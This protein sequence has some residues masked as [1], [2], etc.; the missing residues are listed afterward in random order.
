MPIWK[1]SYFAKNHS[2]V[3]SW[4]KSA[5][6]VLPWREKERVETKNL[7]LEVSAGLR[8]RAFREYFSGELRRDPYRVVVA[9][10]MLQQTQ[11]DRVLPKYQAWMEKWPHIED[12]ARAT[13]AEV[14][15]EW[16]GLGYN[17]RARFLWLLAK[18][19]GETRAGRWPRTEQELLKLPGIGR[20][21]ARAILSF[22]FGQQVA[23]V[24]T[25][26]KRVLGR[27][28]GLVEEIN[29]LA[30]SQERQQ[31]KS[32]AFSSLQPWLNHEQIPHTD[33]NL[34]ELSKL[35]EVRQTF[36]EYGRLTE[37]EWFALADSLL[38]EESADPWNQA[39]MDFGALVC[40]AKNP[41]CDSCPVSGLCVTNQY[42]IS[43]GCDNYAGYLR[44]KK[45]T[46]DLLTGTA[47]H[48]R[49]KMTKSKDWKDGKRLKFEETDRYFRGRILD[50]LR[51]KDWI[52]KDLIE[53]MSKKY[54]LNDSLR[55]HKMLGASHQ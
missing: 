35:R 12:L 40:T 28:L 11:V 37:S 47:K 18:E 26:V 44:E 14:L 5:G 15:I 53:E 7:R 54:G 17:R 16:K 19:I 4:W 27:R 2:A 45:K 51:E 8:E 46:E 22:S 20:Y 41:Q 6:R 32:L 24:D 25:N 55:F 49:K 30:E 23:V 1:K 3:F 29:F 34:V 39:L 48:S 21:T 9:E 38:P 13:L 31:I 10:V 42:A 36:A 52:K 43:R 50:A 33:R